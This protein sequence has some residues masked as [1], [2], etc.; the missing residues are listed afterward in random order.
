[1]VGSSLTNQ[2]FMREHVANLLKSRFPNLTHQQVVD[3]RASAAFETRATGAWSFQS[4]AGRRLLRP[5][6]GPAVLKTHPADFLVQLKEFSAENNQDPYSEEQQQQQ[7]MAAAAAEAQRLAVPG[8]VNPND[9]PMDDDGTL[10]G[11]CD[12]MT[13]TKSSLSV[14]SGRVV[15]EIGRMKTQRIESGSTRD[16]GEARKTGGSAERKASP[17]RQAS[18]PPK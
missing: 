15:G 18:S 14:A 3:F 2:A 7:Q 4:R 16:Q 17:T 6:D 9:R 12:K 13:H 5:A 10:G 8:L 11:G 1:M